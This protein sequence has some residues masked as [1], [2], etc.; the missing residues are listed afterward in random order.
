MP[1]CTKLLIARFF[2][3]FNFLHTKRDYI[4][5]ITLSDDAS[6]STRVI[7]FIFSSTACVF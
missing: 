5:I 6:L 1:Q 3:F 2:F 7:F 4:I